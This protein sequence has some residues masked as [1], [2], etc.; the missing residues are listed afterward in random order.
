[1]SHNKTRI[2]KETLSSVTTII[3]ARVCEV[4]WTNGYLLFFPTKTT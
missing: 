1:M 3:N 4:S 2:E